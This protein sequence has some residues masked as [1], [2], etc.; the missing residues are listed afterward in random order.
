MEEL[1]DL[2]KNI[3][4]EE[5]PLVEWYNTSLELESIDEDLDNH[6]IQE[7]GDLKEYLSN[8]YSWLW[9][10]TYWTKT[11]VGNELDDIITFG[12][13]VYFVSTTGEICYTFSTCGGIPRAGIRPVVTIAI[14][15]IEFNIETKTDGNGEIK[16]NKIKASDG[17]LIEITVTPKH[18]YVLS[19]MTIID[20]NRNKITTKD[21]T[22]VMPAS[23]VVVEAKFIPKNPGTDAFIA[24]GIIVVAIVSGIL[25]I[26]YN[27]KKKQY[28]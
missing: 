2:V 14:S 6:Y 9:N 11:F 12:N 24:T 4:G 28:E 20:A 19:E 23:D 13:Q 5:L 27:N 26:I 16:V 25:V 1:N 17:D 22:F 18:G 10:T 3:S 15:E 21:N 7:L 8:D